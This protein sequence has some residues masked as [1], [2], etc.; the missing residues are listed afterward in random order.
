MLLLEVLCGHV[1]FRVQDFLDA[2]KKQASTKIDKY[3]EAKDVVL[4]IVGGGDNELNDSV[5]F[6][7][8]LFFIEKFLNKKIT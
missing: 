5:S 8:H 4:K 6:V 2:Y 7:L 3:E 1:F